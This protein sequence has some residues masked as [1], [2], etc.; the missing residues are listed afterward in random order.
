MRLRKEKGMTQ[1]ALSEL[2]GISKNHLSGIECG[3]YTPTTQFII[4][5]CNVLG[6]TPDYY[7]I[8]QVSDKTDTLTNLIRGL[9]EN[10]QAMCIKLLE[11]YVAEHKNNL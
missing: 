11:T 9:P 1:E 4:S 5:L 6:R 3:K 7:L 8:G 10:E 2:I